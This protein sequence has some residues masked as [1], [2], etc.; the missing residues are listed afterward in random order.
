MRQSRSKAALKTARER[1]TLIIGQCNI[2]HSPFRYR[3]V[4]FAPGSTVRTHPFG[5]GNNFTSI[6][7]NH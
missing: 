1:Q 3:Y 5:F 6:K 2:Y 7:S 4:S